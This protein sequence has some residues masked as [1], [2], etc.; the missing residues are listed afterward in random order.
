M[1]AA[2]GSIQDAETVERESPEMWKG[3]KISKFC[4]GKDRKNLDK[5]DD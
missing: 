2:G 3:W 1:H 4:G 5:Y